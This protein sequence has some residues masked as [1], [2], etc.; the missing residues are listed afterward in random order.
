MT[1]ASI[2]MHMLAVTAVVSLAGSARAL[3]SGTGSAD[4][5]SRILTVPTLDG[6]LVVDV[7]QP[8]A[9]M[10]AGMLVPGPSNLDAPIAER[11]VELT[12]TVVIRLRDR[13]DALAVAAAYGL[14]TP[15]ARPFGD[16]YF[17]IE[18]TSVADAISLTRVLKSDPRVRFAYVDAAI[19]MVAKDDDED[20]LYPDQW[21]LN[22]DLDGEIDAN[23]PAAWLLGYD[24]GG[25]GDGAR[26]VLVCSVDDGIDVLHEDLIEG[27]IAGEDFN[28]DF[29]PEGDD[30]HN[31][32]HEFSFEAHGTAVA[33]VMAAK[34][35]EFGGRGVA[36]NADLCGIRMLNV[37]LFT[38]DFYEIFAHG[39]VIPDS[40]REIDIKNNSWGRSNEWRVSHLFPEAENGLEFAIQNGRDGK[41][42][43]FCFSAGNGYAVD[44]RAEY[45]GMNASRYTI[46]VGAIA[47]DDKR[48]S[49]SVQ[50]SSILVGAH[51]NGGSRGITTCDASGSDGYTSGNYTNSFGGTSSA[52]PLVSGVV[53]LM[54]DANPDLNWRD[55]QHILVNTAR[56]NDPT[57]VDAPWEVNGDP[58]N[59]N[60]GGHDINYSYGFGA[61]DAGA[62]VA[63][64]RAWSLDGTATAPVTELTQVVPGLPVAIPDG[65]PITFDVEFVSDD[66]DTINCDENP[67]PIEHV[68]LI[69]STEDAGEGSGERGD[70]DIRI[71]SPWGTES[72]LA[73]ARLDGAYKDDGEYN[74][75]I[76][77]SVRHWDECP[78]G[79]WTIEIE[80]RNL[81]SISDQ[82][83]DLELRLYLG[84]IEPGKLIGDVDGDGDVD[85]S[86][87]G[88][89]LASFE[90]DIDD[91]NYNPDADFDE[92]GDVD[93]SDLGALLANFGVGT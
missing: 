45:G 30:P 29:D 44:G 73:E 47:D 90:L 72:I 3:D 37:P 22:N 59:P 66:P 28:L 70:L 14:G 13:G 61:V 46:T 63:M 54:L 8:D 84:G 33:G 82:L 20:P 35:N 91:P 5:N 64:A 79:T 24:G 52:C 51:S 56:K 76:F 2:A 81:A 18:S 86:D 36:Y 12:S 50:G 43:V 55:V 48:S 77:T 11:R 21:H 25:S 92:D 80:D 71:I 67:L 7:Q 40:E 83:T 65:S 15:L 16:A 57:G 87:L 17:E 58:D 27:Y 75:F 60:N 41:G 6:P 32:D 26:A 1:Y 85:I 49:Y 68:E 19:P 88:A 23:V 9:V 62:A 89:L 78:F 31:P 39:V 42:T 93:L 10:S 74:S 69:I 34:R 4:A 53:A 38:D